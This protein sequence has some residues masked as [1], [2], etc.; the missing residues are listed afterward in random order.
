MP[1]E[2][3]HNLI[4]Y[5]IISLP[6]RLRPPDD[7]PGLRHVYQD[8]PGC[9]D[10]SYDNRRSTKTNLTQ[11]YYLIEGKLEGEKMLPLLPHYFERSD[12]NMKWNDSVDAVG[13]HQLRDRFEPL[14]LELQ[15]WCKI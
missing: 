8:W 5:T 2:P 15:Q 12:M 9:Q 1:G 14:M 4:S 7:Q 6:I 11:F 3:L 10:R 13:T